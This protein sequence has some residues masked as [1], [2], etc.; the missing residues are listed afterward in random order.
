MLLS[1]LG[2]LLGDLLEGRGELGGTLDKGLCEL[3][4]RGIGI[5]L[6]TSVVS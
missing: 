2:Y 5:P 1:L 6:V 3:S 4:D